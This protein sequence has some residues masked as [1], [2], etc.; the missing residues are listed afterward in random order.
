MF[1]RVGSP[2]K[3]EKVIAFDLKTAKEIFCPNPDCKSYVGLSSG[4]TYKQAGGKPE[5][6]VDGFQAKCPKCKGS[7]NV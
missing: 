5:I 7:F 6:L 2:S 1:K 4:G 3:I